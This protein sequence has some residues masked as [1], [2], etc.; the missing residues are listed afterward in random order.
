MEGGRY[1]MRR[2][3]R[4]RVEEP[5]RPA[6]A[7]SGKIATEVPVAAEAPAPEADSSKES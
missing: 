3:R 2:G 4:V 1:E 5:T 6:E 7:P